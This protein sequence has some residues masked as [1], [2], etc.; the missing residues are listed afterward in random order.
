MCGG[1]WGRS[2]RG[3]GWEERGGGCTYYLLRGGRLGGASLIEK[4]GRG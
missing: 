3:D 1:V 4:R 2:R